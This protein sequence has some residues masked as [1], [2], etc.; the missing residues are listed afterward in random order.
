MASVRKLTGLS[1]AQSAFDKKHEQSS[2][3]KR[4]RTVT[5]EWQ[6]LKLWALAGR[7]ILTQEDSALATLSS[8]HIFEKRKWLISPVPNVCLNLWHRERNHDHNTKNPSLKFS[9]SQVPNVMMTERLHCFL[10]ARQMFVL[11]ESQSFLS[12][13]HEMLCLTFLK[14]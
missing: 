11:P 13:T 14:G 4:E 6:W 8:P 10:A 7:A 5:G 9:L 1:V 2:L 12:L 3:D